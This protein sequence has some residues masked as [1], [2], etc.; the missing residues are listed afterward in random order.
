MNIETVGAKKLTKKLQQIERIFEPAV[1]R[2]L[3]RTLTR[4]RTV[5]AKETRRQTGLPSAMIKKDLVGDKASRRRLEARLVATPPSPKGSGIP[6][7]RFKAKATKR[8]GVSFQT[9]VPAGRQRLKNAFMLTPKQGG[10]VVA[11]RR[12]DSGGVR[13]KNQP[14]KGWSPSNKGRK[15]GTG[16]LDFPYGPSVDQVFA[17]SSAGF[18]ASVRQ[19]AR[20][21]GREFMSR[22][23]DREIKYRVNKIWSR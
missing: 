22:E 14:K 2:V 13:V 10:L 20:R 23:L 5:A 7:G 18:G 21:A 3:N 16:Y 9:G 17:T 11:I 15:P 8:K 6:L 19:R 12:K 1:H 4:S